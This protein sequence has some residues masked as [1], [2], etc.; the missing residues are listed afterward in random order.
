MPMLIYLTVLYFYC[1]L[2]YQLQ[3]AGKL[4][5]FAGVSAEK[6]VTVNRRESSDNPATP[7]RE[8]AAAAAADSNAGTTSP[9]CDEQPSDHDAA[10]ASADAILQDFL[11]PEP[12]N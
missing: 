5:F 10:R 4:H 12:G 1:L 3:A 2:E 11:P 9:E 8:A 6:T 7:E